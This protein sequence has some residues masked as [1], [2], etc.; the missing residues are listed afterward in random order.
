MTTF[1]TEFFDLALSGEWTQTPINDHFEYV[2]K[3][4]QLIINASRSKHDLNEQELMHAGLDA[5][6]SRIEV[7]TAG[8]IKVSAPAVEK[9]GTKWDAYLS[10]IGSETKVYHQ[11]AILVRPQV[12]LIVGY[13]RYVG[14]IDE[15]A[16]KDFFREA[17]NVLWQIS[18]KK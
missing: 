16:S 14:R 2:N 8:G 17:K 3:N 13:Y 15:A 5:A 11:S 1:T 9:V 6:K 18:I 4:D 12:M 7:L 10:G